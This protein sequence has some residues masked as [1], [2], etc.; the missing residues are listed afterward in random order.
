MKV[1]VVSGLYYMFAKAGI[2]EMASHN[3]ALP[4][5]RIFNV[6]IAYSYFTYFNPHQNCGWWNKVLKY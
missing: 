5:P 6:I 1:K 2:Q 3:L 4:S